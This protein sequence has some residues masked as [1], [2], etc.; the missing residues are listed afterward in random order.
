MIKLLFLTLL[1]LPIALFSKSD[2]PSKIPLPEITVFNLDP[3]PCDEACVQKYLKNGLIFS[4][5]S[6]QDFETQNVFLSK[7]KIYYATVM[8]D[9]SIKK[10]K[11]I[12]IALL[13]PYKTIGRYAAS[14]TNASFAYLMSTDA[15][16]EL[17]SYKIEDESYAEIV[18]A[19]DKIKNDG[20]EYVIA[21]LTQAGEK[22][23]ARINPNINIYFPTINKKDAKD[24]TRYLY[25][26]GID[27]RAQID[28]L[29]RIS[30]SPLVIFYDN[31]EIAQQLSRYE[32][33]S[34]KEHGGRSVVKF[35]IPQQIT[36]LE[37][38]IKDNS[39]ISGGSFFLNTPIVKSGM[40]MSQLTLYDTDVK[41][42]F[43]TQANYNPLLLSMTQYRDRKEMIIA[44]SITQNDDLLIETNSILQNDIVYDWINYTTTVGM[45]YFSHLISGEKR[46]YNIEVSSNQMIYP[47]KLLQPSVSRFIPYN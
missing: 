41:N 24:P 12:R 17:K 26:G 33:S 38:Q 13:M 30:S 47:I 44:N 14:T 21:P 19:L 16:F 43:S 9:D 10:K 45:D 32:E 36:N 23:V 29:L 5:L 35:E 34:F 39:K 22:V 7:E 28:M 42:I 1:L 46:R 27:Y 15:P 6:H 18:A 4:Y 37:K 11:K 3:Y 2:Q 25:Y 31:S 20:F 8:K 40:I